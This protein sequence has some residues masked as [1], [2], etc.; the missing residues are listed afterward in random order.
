MRLAVYNVENLFDRAKV[1]NLDSWETGRPVL[2]DFAALNALLAKLNYSA[3]DKA[4]MADLMV[5]L[6]LEK[7]DQA[8]F[9]LL[10]RNR[11]SLLKRP[12][13]G[14]IVITANGRADWVGSLELLDEPIRHEA[15]VNTA[16]VMV[17]VDADVMGIVEAENRPSLHEFNRVMIQEAGGSPYRHVMVIDGNDSRG[18]DVGLMSREGFPICRMC[19]HVDDRLAGGAL[20]FSRDCP[21][22][23]V[24]T[25][26]GNRLVVLVNHLKSKGYGSPAASN[27]RRQAQAQRV[28]EIYEDLRADGEKLIAI[29]GDLNDTPDS[30]PLAPL[31]ADSDL[32]DA[33]AHD[34]FDDGGFP[35]TYGGSGKK[36]KIDYILLSPE[37]YR[38][39]TAGGIYRKGMW[40]GV[41]P[42]KWPVLPQIKDPRDVASDHAALWVDLNI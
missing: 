37:L 13:T 22:Y 30:A 21:E 1:M 16:R 6:G 2:E 7:N 27:A 3:A 25:P 15:V 29:V 8:K 18:I 17:D 32:K 14:G 26:S 41:R 39:V 24:T 34:A 28:K 38:A 9:V 11:G 35:G 42:A 31:L 19:S 10:R 5:S 36:N 12:K 23:Q 20:V 40:P 33:Q 4:N